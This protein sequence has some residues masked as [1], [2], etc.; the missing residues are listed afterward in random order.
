MTPEA[1][2][3]YWWERK[4]LERVLLACG[5]TFAGAALMALVLIKPAVSAI[6][7][8]QHELPNTRAQVARLENL[9]S[10]V[11]MLRS[12]PAVTVAADSPA[13]IEQSLAAAGLKPVRVL[14][15]PDGALQLTFADVPYA[16]WSI[17]LATAEPV[18]GMHATAVAANATSTPGNVDVRLELQSGRE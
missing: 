6:A 3:R 7:R 5:I 12:R 16:A 17:W 14:P 8:L 18:L 9:L 15:L 4:P 11:R 13:A 1:L 10:E 2:R